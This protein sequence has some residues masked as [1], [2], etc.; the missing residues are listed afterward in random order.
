MTILLRKRWENWAE[1]SAEATNWYKLAYWYT[2]RE[3]RYYIKV[4]IVMEYI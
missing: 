2:R 3:E 4:K 1:E